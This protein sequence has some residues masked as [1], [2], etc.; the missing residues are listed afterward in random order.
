M[1]SGLPQDSAQLCHAVNNANKKK[2]AEFAGKIIRN[3]TRVEISFK[4]EEPKPISF[5]LFTREK[6]I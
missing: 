6:Y 3:P 2:L 4:W 1:T 5:N